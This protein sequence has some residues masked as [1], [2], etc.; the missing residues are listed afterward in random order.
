MEEGMENKV[1]EDDV[2]EHALNKGI[3]S[4]ASRFKIDKEEVYRIVRKFKSEVDLPCPCEL[5]SQKGVIEMC[6][7]CTGPTSR[8]LI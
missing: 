6:F 2:L 3:V 1:P 4:A 7:A 8:I 5:A